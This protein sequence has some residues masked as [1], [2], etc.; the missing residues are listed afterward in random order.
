MVEEKQLSKIEV[1]PVEN[2]LEVF[3]VA[4]DWR[5]KKAVLDDIKRKFVN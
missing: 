5:G 2:I 1:V 3:E 4:L